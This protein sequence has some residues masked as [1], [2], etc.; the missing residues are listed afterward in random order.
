MQERPKNFLV[1]LRLKYGPIYEIVSMA[2]YLAIVHAWA[3]GLPAFGQDYQLLALPHDFA[4][5][6]PA[7]FV[8]GLHAFF[9]GN[10]AAYRLLSALL[11]LGCMVC[12]YSSAG[13]VIRGPFWIGT[14]AA[15]L[16][17]SNP[18]TGRVML[19]LLGARQLLPCLL[20]LIAFTLYAAHR[21]RP[22]AWRYGGALLLTALASAFPMAAPLGIVIL[23]YEL[24]CRPT[25]AARLRPALPFA[26]VGAAAILL[27]LPRLA[28]APELLLERTAGLYFLFY[29]IGFLPETVLT[30]LRMPWLGVL[31]A[32]AV[33]ALLVLVMRKARHSAIGFGL[34]AALL[35]SVFGAGEGVHLVHME[36]MDQLILA[37]A[38]FHI[39]AAALFTRMMQHPKWTVTVV[40]FTTILCAVFFLMQIHN[41]FT[42]RDAARRVAH[43]QRESAAVASEGG[44]V[45]VLPDYQYMSGAPLRLSDAIAHDT[46]FSRAVP[47]AALLPLNAADGLVVHLKR[48]QESTVLLRAAGAR[49]IDVVASAGRLARGGGAM[50][51]GAYS[52]ETLKTEGE[53][54]LLRLHVKAVDEL[55]FVPGGSRASADPG[56]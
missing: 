52:A 12:V 23:L 43:F 22:A 6:V 42:W 15:V 21:A 45:G 54:L 2:V 39:A 49:P 51:T 34:A 8:E 17:M 18:S 11:M 36:G 19:Q 44:T 9:A 48:E 27:Y 13:M 7:Y 32:L 53:E 24:I 14:L 5:A 47:H 28:Q 10:A 50:A 37:G 33:L 35:F 38:F 30:F 56:L 4:A 46:A 40:G 25:Q 31:A 3:F 1:R 29:P 41:A 55:R 26:F 16:F 20:A